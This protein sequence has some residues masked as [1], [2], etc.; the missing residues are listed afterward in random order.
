MDLTLSNIIKPIDWTAKNKRV[1]IEH[2]K[3]FWFGKTGD[4][5]RLRLL[6]RKSNIFLILEDLKGQTIVCRTS[7]VAG[8][9]GSKRQKRNPQALEYI[10]PSLYPYL[11]IYGIRRFNIILNTRMNGCM[12]MLLRELEKFKLSVV[13][14]SVRRRVAYNGCRGR[15]KRRT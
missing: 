6:R 15:K 2:Q 7:G 4:W 5:G 10:F 9:I 11:K 8:L 13:K 12:Y 1:G 14:C 3:H